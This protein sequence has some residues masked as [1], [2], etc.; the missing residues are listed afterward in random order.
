MKLK[1]GNIA[2]LRSGG[3]NMTVESVASDGVWCLWFEGKRRNR[4]LFPASTLERPRTRPMK[5][6]NITIKF[7]DG[8]GNVVGTRKLSDRG[9]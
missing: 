8:Q 1:A 5:P 2:R 9:K 7:V 6:P 3:P 4:K